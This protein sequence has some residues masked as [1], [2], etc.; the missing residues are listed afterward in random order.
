M[1]P[2][3]RRMPLSPKNPNWPWFG[4]MKGF[5]R[6]GFM[7]NRPAPMNIRMMAILRKTMTELILADSLM[8]TTSS[9]VIMPMT[10]AAG[11]LITAPVLVQTPVM[12]SNAYGDEARTA[13]KLM[14]RSLRKLT[15]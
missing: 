10:R 12:G 6:L 5:Q 8:P 13:G 4:G 3:P 9:M 1:T 14:P 11:R 2:A 7:K 15:M